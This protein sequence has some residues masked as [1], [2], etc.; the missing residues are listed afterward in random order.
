MLQESRII[1]R[2]TM[3]IV[4]LNG[5]PLKDGN[6]SQLLD[7]FSRTS[8]EF[9]AAV[10]TIHLNSISYR[11]C[12]A[13]MKCKG[14]SEICVVRDDLAAVLDSVKNADVLV[15][16]SPIYFGEVTSQMKAFIDRTFSYLKPEFAGSRLIPGKTLVMVL[17]Q[18]SA[19]AG[20][21]HDVYP[22]Y[23]GFFKWFGYDKRYE[24]RGLGLNGPEDAAGREDL[25]ERV[26]DVAR[27]IA[28]S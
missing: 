23:A 18:G 15:L 24:I 8:S 12:Q 6:T 4:C 3:K 20:S 28:G 7:V 22:R 14:E 25:L 17:P 26:R 9:G 19:D 10:E 13:C 21:F 27:E 2:G 1:G 11:G 5:S 16:G